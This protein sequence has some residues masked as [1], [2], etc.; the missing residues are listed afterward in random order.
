[1]ADGFEGASVDDIARAAKRP[2]ATL[3]SYFPDKRLLFME[4]ATSECTRMADTV[5]DLI[6]E[7][8]PVREVLAIA[9]KQF[10]ELCKVRLWTG[11]ISGIQD[12]LSG[13]EIG[14]VMGNADMF[15]ARYGT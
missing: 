8:H 3:N 7:A 10:S 2:K 9:A 13:D 1:M 5:V 14:A 12:D 15:M 6:D 4:A 11:A